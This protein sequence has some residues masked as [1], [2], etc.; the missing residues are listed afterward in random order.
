MFSLTI[1]CLT[2]DNL[3]W[4]MDLIFQVPRQYCSL[5]HLILL[6]PPGTSTTR[7]HFHFID[8]KWSSASSFLLKL[9]VL[10]WSISCSIEHW[11][12]DPQI[13]EQLYKISS[14]TFAKVLGH[15]TDFPT[16]GSDK[17]TEPL[18]PGI[19]LW[20]PVA[21][22]YRTSTGLGKQT[23]G[24]HKQNFLLTRTQEKWAVTLQEIEPDQARNLWWRCRL[25]EACLEVRNT[26]YNSLGSHSLLT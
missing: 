12:E 7:H 13:G 21:F 15:T 2:T 24:G 6:S 11:A 18:L 26:D 3:H 19:W 14:H 17:R 16:R 20:R 4:F 25:T 22:D 23:L 5:Q 1:F 10:S 9:F 8:M